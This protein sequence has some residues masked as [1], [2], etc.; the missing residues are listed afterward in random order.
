MESHSLKH[1]SMP[2]YTPE[3][4]VQDHKPKT[5]NICLE[6]SKKRYELRR[7]ISFSDQ[8]A[9]MLE[10]VM[11]NRELE[12]EYI[13]SVSVSRGVQAAKQQSVAGINTART[14]VVGQG[15]NHTEGGWPK[16]INCADPEQTSRYR[17]KFEK[18]EEFIDTFRKNQI[19]GLVNLCFGFYLSPLEFRS[20]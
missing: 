13:R 14:E 19:K 12:K 17:K 4:D 18:D 6:I 15:M 10:E 3:E 16:D 2:Y 1:S 20:Y 9:S 7:P 11:P 5:R 8:E